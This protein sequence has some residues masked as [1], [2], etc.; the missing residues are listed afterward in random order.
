MPELPSFGGWRP[1]EFCR[2]ERRDVVRRR[3][4][5]GLG[6]GSLVFGE[7]L[8]LGVVGAG[9]QARFSVL[10]LWTYPISCVIY[11]LS[12]PHIGCIAMNKNATH[13]GHRSSKSGQ[14]VTEGKAKRSPAT[15]QR[16]QI[17]NP[18]RGDT[19]RRKGTK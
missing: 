4:F 13:T 18:G 15:H 17:P 10:S 2:D 11:Y 14:F 12:I 6:C 16:E 19:A 3:G 1:P 8:F 9:S 5:W 7:G